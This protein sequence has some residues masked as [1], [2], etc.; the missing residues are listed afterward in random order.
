MSQREPNDYRARRLSAATH[1][2]RGLPAAK[3]AAAATD[4][5]SVGARDAASRGI[6]RKKPAAVLARLRPRVQLLRRPSPPCNVPA[7]R[8]PQSRVAL[9]VVAGAG[10]TAAVGI[11]TITGIDTHADTDTPGAG[12]GAALRATAAAGRGD[13]AEV[14]RGGGGGGGFFLSTLAYNHQIAS[15]TKRVDAARL[16]LKAAEESLA[17]LESLAAVESLASLSSYDAAARGG[18]TT[19]N[20]SEAAAA[21]EEEA[22]AVDVGA[23]EKVAA[24]MLRTARGVCVVDGCGDARTPLSRCRTC[25]GHKDARAVSVGGVRARE[26]I[27]CRTLH[28]LTAF[29]DGQRNCRMVQAR[30]SLAYKRRKAN[31]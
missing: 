16:E 29:K 11:D 2:G 24:A 19:G 4:A 18:H 5:A 12:A 27:T 6:K 7:L 10:E 8:A 25:P 23:G 14:S 30:A 3:E 20:E 13:V 21:A 28:P 1:T 15:A 22:E 9:V 17:E 31:V 26:C